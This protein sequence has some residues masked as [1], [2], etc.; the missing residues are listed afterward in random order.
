MNQP[1]VHLL[2]A[3]HDEDVSQPAALLRGHLPVLKREPSSQVEWRAR[4]LTSVFPAVLWLS[5]CPWPVVD[6][7]GVALR[8]QCKIS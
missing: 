7:V 5:G 2:A 4:G 1:A 3:L 6:T 8:L